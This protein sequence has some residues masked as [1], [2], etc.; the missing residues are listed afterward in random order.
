MMRWI[1]F[2]SLFGIYLASGLFIVRGN[3]LALVRRFGR[4]RLPLAASGLHFDLPWP[5]T[6]IDRVNTNEVRNLTI[7]VSTTEPLE[8]SGFLREINVDRQGEFL[9]GD[10]NILNLSVHVQY[11]IGDPYA[12]L[13]RGANPEAGLKLLV[14][15]LVTDTVSRSGVDYV[16]PL[17]LNELRALLS[18]RAR[19][20][21]ERHPWGVIVDD[22]T[23]AGAFPPVEVKAAFLDVSNARAERDRMI[24]QQQ[25]QGEKRIAAARAIAEREHDR[26]EAERNARIENARGAA[27]RFRAIV[28]AFERDAGS[29]DDIAGVRRRSMQ[30]LYSAAMEEW[31][32]RLS[33]KVLIDPRDSVDL[34]IFPPAE[35][36]PGKTD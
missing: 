6:R 32:P 7:G 8:S 34:T 21:A 35:P 27:D 33:G 36:L 15:S 26:A 10:K 13:C 22:V 29:A 4:A 18:R 5:F 16:H 1:L 12:W 31:L 24:N 19:E 20:A 28:A 9:T 17:G 23:I 30:R 2:G 25:A 3:E 11:R 14:E